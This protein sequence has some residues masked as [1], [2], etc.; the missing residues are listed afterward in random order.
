MDGIEKY[1]QNNF[2]SPMRRS[3]DLDDNFH[4]QYQEHIDKYG[5]STEE[6]LGVEDE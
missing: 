3:L 1:V 6:L 2:L 5:I 4:D